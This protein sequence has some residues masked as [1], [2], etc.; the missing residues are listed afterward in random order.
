MAEPSF[1]WVNQYRIVHPK[2]KSFLTAFALCGNVTDASDKAEIGCKTHY[3]WMNLEH[4]ERDAYR[5]A[6]AEAQER[7]FVVLERE[8]RRRAVDGV[9]NPIFD[10][11]GNLVGHEIKYSDTM[12]IFLMKG[13]RPDVYRETFK[14]E[15]SGTVNLVQE[16]EGA[17]ELARKRSGLPAE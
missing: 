4:D 16:L 5:E 10:K 13:L 15:H 6:F 7:A 1:D 14:H 11:D 12:L 8:A 17:V 9:E 3:G 2:K